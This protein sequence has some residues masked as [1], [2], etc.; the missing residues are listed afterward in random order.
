VVVP[1]LRAIAFK[2]GY[3]AGLDSYTWFVVDGLACGALVAVLVRLGVTRRHNWWTAVGLIL[4]TVGLSAAGTPFGVLTRNSML[5]AAFQLTLISILFSG[6]LLAF[7][8]MGTGK[9]RRLTNNSTLRFF[10]YI[11]YG[12]YLVHLLM[13]RLYDKLCNRFDPALL[14]RSYHL[15]LVVLRFV[16]AGGGAVL[17]AYASRVYFENWFLRLKDRLAASEG[18]PDQGLAVREG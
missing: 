4:A 14:P 10:G 11:S 2:F 5:G 18:A 1:V 7:L 8:L 13:F 9:Y 6:V 12:L 17:L 16:V 15:E 3:T